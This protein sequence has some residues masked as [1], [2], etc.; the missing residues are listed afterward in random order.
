MKHRLFTILTLLLLA[1]LIAPLQRPAFAHP[2]PV[3]HGRDATPAPGYTLYLPTIT[4]GAASGE[5]PANPL[6]ITIGMDATR[7]V[8]STIDAEGGTL[9]TTAADGTRF[10]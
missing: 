10:S 3:M 1:A 6:T 2:T 9:S 7:A 5:P 4:G 8:S